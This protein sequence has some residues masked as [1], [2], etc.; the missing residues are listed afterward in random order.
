MALF[1]PALVMCAAMAACSGRSPGPELPL[2]P[3]LRPPRDAGPPCDALSCRV[4]SCPRGGDTIVMG[5]VT[6][7]NGVDPI[8]EALVYV[9]Q[10]GRPDDFPAGVSC[11]AC[12]SP[13][14]GPVVTR[15]TTDIDGS[16]VLR[17]VPATAETPI[18]IQKGRF[19]RIVSAPIA[20]C[21]NNELPPAQTRLPRAQAEGNLPRMAV[22]AG[23]WDSIECVLRHIGIADGEFTSSMGQGAVHLYNNVGGGR[24]GG[25]ASVTE[26]LGDVERM[27][28]YD[29]IF[30]NCSDH[31]N[32]R[33]L[34]A[35]ARVRQNLVDY[36]SRGGRIYVTDYSYDFVQQP[37]PFAPFI[38]FNDDQPCTVLEPHGFATATRSDRTARER[39]FIAEVEQGT[40]GGRALAEWLSRLPQPI[41]DGRVPIEDPISTFVLIR[42][43]AA[44]QVKYPSTTWLSATLQGARR[45]VTVT[46]D[47]PVAPQQSCGKV[48]YSSYHTRERRSPSAD[49]PGYCPAGPMIPQEKVLEFLI[50]EISACLGTIPG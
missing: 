6:A 41:P 1:C 44:D 31:T 39:S 2:N 29:L 22:A 4:P 8:R 33:G 7:P 35:Q 24:G 34:L 16:F 13:T 50:F 32:S 42:Q 27:A 20:P 26:L 11:D 38:C 37:A 12:D 23:N 36:V 43:T 10:S 47:Y 25:L 21:V 48:L 30:L 9:P 49:F 14:V 19:R 40:E 3:D 17:R 45:P 28:R 46:F 18:V 5:K 15:T